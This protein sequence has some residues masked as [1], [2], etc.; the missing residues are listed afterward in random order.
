VNPCRRS[1]RSSLAAVAVAIVSVAANT[2]YLP[3]LRVGEESSKRGM[4][5]LNSVVRGGV[6]IE[7]RPQR[8]VMKSS[9]PLF[10]LCAGAH[11]ISMV[12]AACAGVGSFCL[13]GARD[14]GGS[15]DTT[16]SSI[17]P[18]PVWRV[19]YRACGP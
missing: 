6:E 17:S 11:A 4:A 13:T 7:G 5:I 12:V 1:G 9:R 2:A 15:G 18:Q 10:R 3:S 19:L 16:N 8:E 14:V